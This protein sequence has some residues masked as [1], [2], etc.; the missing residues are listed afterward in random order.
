MKLFTQWKKT[1][2]LDAFTL[3]L[4]NLLLILL[5]SNF[6]QAADMKDVDLYAL[7][8]GLEK[9]KDPSIKSTPMAAAATQ[10]NDFLIERRGLFRNVKVA[11]LLDEK[12]TKANI[13]KVL[14]EELKAARKDDI[15][16]IFMNAH[17]MATETA[18]PANSIS[19]PMIAILKTLLLDF[20]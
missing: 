2:M 4:L 13:L 7:I 11:L 1:K 5:S 12:A 19:F 15:V 14:K 8:V 10:L 18:S 3:A 9:Y 6:I 16:L 20:N 17:G